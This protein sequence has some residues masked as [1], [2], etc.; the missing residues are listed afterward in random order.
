MIFLVPKG[1]ESHEMAEIFMKLP[2]P[3]RRRFLDQKFDF[4]SIFCRMKA[5][6]LDK[7]KFW[8]V[9]ILPGEAISKWLVDSRPKVPSS[10]RGEYSFTDSIFLP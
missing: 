4:M 1:L 9:N 5:L 2:A 8:V 6:K 7:T 3:P 10:I